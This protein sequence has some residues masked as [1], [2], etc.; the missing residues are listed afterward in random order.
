MNTQFPVKSKLRLSYPLSFV[1][2]LF[3]ASLS[4]AGLLYPD[5]LYPASELRSSF[6]PNDVVNLFIGLPILLGSMW[7]TAHAKLIGLLAWPGALLY[8]IYNYIAYIFAIPFSLV[9]ILYIAL[10]LVSAYVIF[11][12]M[13]NID[14][15]SVQGRISETVPVK[16][17]GWVLVLF[18]VLFTFRAVDLIVQAVI[19]QSGLAASEIGV[20][21][22]DL[23]ISPL[24]LL[25]GILLLRRK[26]LGYASGLGLLFAGSMLFVGLIAFLL[27]QPLL[28]EASFAPLDV[29]V[30]AV[31]GLVCFIPFGLFVRGVLSSG[32]PADGEPDLRITAGR[33]TE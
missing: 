6:T 26:P 31:M 29:L 21:V 22:A 33:E 8:I 1:I 19:N 24:W 11:E 16:I 12:L 20:L 10:V 27:L 15:K 25:G 9:S 30:V 32:A 3:M 23:V 13:R 28:T 18:G 2:S 7:L 17:A 14:M 4:L 5:K